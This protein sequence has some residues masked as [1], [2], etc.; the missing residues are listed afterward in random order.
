METSG[1]PTEPGTLSFDGDGH[2]FRDA[3]ILAV[4]L[5]AAAQLIDMD[6]A[7]ADQADPATHAKENAWRST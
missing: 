6:L 3:L 1:F 4:L 2:E 5:T 7:L